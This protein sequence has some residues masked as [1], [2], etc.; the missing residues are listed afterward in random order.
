MTKS[1]SQADSRVI[2]TLIPADSALNYQSLAELVD[3]VAHELNN[4]IAV[5]L[6]HVQLLKLKN[7]DENVTEGLNRIEKS[8]F[9]CGELIKAIQEYAGGPNLKTETPVAISDS[10]VAAL[11]LDETSWKEN[12]SK[13]NLTIVSIIEEECGTINSD[14]S[15]LITAI[16][17]LIHNA[18]DAS[19]NN[20]TIEITVRDKE[21]LAQLSISDKGNGISDKLKLKI[22]EPFV[23]T[24]KSKV[25]GLGLTIVQS[26]VARWGGRIGF[27]NSIA[28]GTTFTVSFPL[29]SNKNE[30][31]KVAGK[32]A[33]EKRILIVDDDEE[34][35]NVLG[36]ML[37]IEGFQAENCSNAYSAMELLENAHFD[38]VIT[39]LGMPGMSGY[40]L[41]DYVREKYKDTE[42]VLLTGWGNSLKRDGKELKG[43]K[44]IISKPFRLND[45]LELVRN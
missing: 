44:A 20:G 1:I 9:K 16:S 35:R 29:I 3:G 24:K 13:K 25:S 6:G 2:R 32:K 17:H 41:A 26:I 5:A 36:D 31:D 11:G 7:K 12:A 18:V 42:I 21:D 14:K 27:S 34:I 39:D 43:I 33:A 28:S 4:N 10:L 19:P 40:D 23:S 22:Y 37:K 8:I 45:V 30:V 15:D 38:M